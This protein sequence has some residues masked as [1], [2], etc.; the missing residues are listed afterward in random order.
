MRWLSLF[1]NNHHTRIQASQTYPRQHIKRTT[2]RSPRMR[3]LLFLLWLTASKCSPHAGSTISYAHTESS[4][5]VVYTQSDS[6]LPCG[7]GLSLLYAKDANITIQNA[8]ALCKYFAI[9]DVASYVFIIVFTFEAYNSND[10]FYLILAAIAIASCE[11]SFLGLLIYCCIPFD[12]WFEYT[13]YSR[14]D[15]T[16]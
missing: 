3:L 11:L 6:A 12:S 8:P 4:G 16:G 2:R 9:R 1:D 7:L 14:L 13:H 15:G 10:L 5:A